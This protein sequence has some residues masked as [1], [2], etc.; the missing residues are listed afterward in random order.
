MKAILTIVSSLTGR[1][2][3]ISVL[4]RNPFAPMPQISSEHFVS[5]LHRDGYF[6]S[7]VPPLTEYSL[8]R[9]RSFPSAD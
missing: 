3:V 2:Q 6:G 7:L 4:V 5:Y 1:P 8:S 9:D